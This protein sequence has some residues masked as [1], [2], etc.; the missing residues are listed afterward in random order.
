MIMKKNML[1]LVLA[2][3]MLLLLGTDGVLA[4]APTEPTP[5]GFAPFQYHVGPGGATPSST[6]RTATLSGSSF[7]AQNSVNRANTVNGIQVRVT[8]VATTASPGWRYRSQSSALAVGTNIQGG[9]GTV[10]ISI[11][12]SGRADFQVRY[13]GDARWH[14]Q[15][16]ITRA[17]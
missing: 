5:I 12:Q 17:R 14:H 9:S 2:S 6:N 3:A 1:K 7:T 13:V 4:T 15:T 16:S 10:Q 8:N 11:G